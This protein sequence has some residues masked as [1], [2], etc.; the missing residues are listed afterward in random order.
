M[1]NKTSFVY[2]NAPFLIIILGITIPSLV[3][4]DMSRR[5]KVNIIINIY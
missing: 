1:K 4:Y 2:R 3:L 5:V